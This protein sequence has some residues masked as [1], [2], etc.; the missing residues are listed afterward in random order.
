MDANKATADYSVAAA[1]MGER[2]EPVA[3]SAQER[4]SQES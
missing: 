1:E 3:T 4:V 2:I